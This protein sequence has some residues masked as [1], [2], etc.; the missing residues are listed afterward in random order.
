LLEALIQIET[1]LYRLEINAKPLAIIE[2]LLSMRETTNGSMD[3]AEL[4]ESRNDGNID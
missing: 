2:Q 3:K 1:F 4:T